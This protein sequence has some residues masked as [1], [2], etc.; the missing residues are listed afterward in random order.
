MNPD[1]SPLSTVTTPLPDWVVAASLVLFV[2]SLTL[3]TV[4]PAQL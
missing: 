1:S 2:L 3:L 4:L